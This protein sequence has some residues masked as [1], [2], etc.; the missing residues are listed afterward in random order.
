MPATGSWLR[1]WPS[2]WSDETE[3]VGVRVRSSAAARRAAVSEIEADE[4]RHG[5][6]LGRRRPAT[7]REL[8][9]E[10]GDRRKEQDRDDAGD[11]H[12]RAR[13]ALVVVG[14]WRARQR[15]RRRRRGSA[16][17][18]P[19]IGA[20][21][22][23]G[24]VGD[25]ARVGTGGRGD[26]RRPGGQ[27][28]RSRGCPRRT[29]RSPT[30]G[31]E[32]RVEGVGHRRRRRPPVVRIERQRLAGDRGEVGRHGRP[33][34][35]RV[36]DRAAQPGE[37]DRCRAVAFPRPD[38]GEHLVQDDAEAVDVRGGR[39]LLA[40]G[41]FRA[42]VVD[43]A[44]RRPRQRHLGFGDRPRDPEVGDLHLAVASR[45][46]CCRAS[47]HGGRGLGRGRRRGPG[48]ACARSGAT[49]RGGSAPL[50]RRMV[51]RSSPSTSSMTM[52]GPLGSSPKS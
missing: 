31:L 36:G 14:G 47:R 6:L 30:A 2:G 33:D 23:V 45:S 12:E 26:H 32:R 10:E 5:D 39:R 38:P 9:D 34:G 4:V 16:R 17:A 41:L 13:P 20:D 11:P 50:R 51:A 7:A 52:N 43:R 35:R 29:G 28:G 49:W 24:D 27:T 19:G 42:E 8:E 22:G 21:V 48:R 18:Q 3:P 44:E 40:A 15:R 25:P 37:G 46:G 1:T